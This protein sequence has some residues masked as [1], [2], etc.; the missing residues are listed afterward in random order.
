MTG[1]PDSGVTAPAGFR[2]SGVRCGIRANQ[3]DLALLVSEREAA[4]AAVFTRNRVQAAPVVLSRQALE[5]SGG[6][7]RAVVVNSGNANACTGPAGDLAARR[8]AEELA[9][10]LDLPVDRVLV[11]STGVIGQ[12]LPVD[13]LIDGLP[14]AIAELSPAGGGDAAEAI[15]TTD[16]CR[17]ESVRRVDEPAGGYTLGGMVKGSGMIHP[18]LATT[19]AFV[20]TDAAL[21]PATLAAILRRAADRS[22]N[23]L[24][25]DGDTSTNDMIGLLANG[26]SGVAPDGE[27]FERALT[28]LLVEMARAVARDGEGATR[29]LTVRVVA[30]AT[31]A[32][33]LAVARTVA[34]SLLV[35]TAVHGADANWGRIA[36]AAGRAGVDLEPEALAVRI[37]GLEVLSPGYRSEFSEEEASRRLA[38]DEVVLEVD[39]A[40]GEA[41]AS[42]WTCDLSERYIQIN[43]DYRT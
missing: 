5:S 38:A 9:R 7:A 16:P 35:K 37:N 15:L 19:L 24:T 36:A 2:A 12:P 30:A 25:V 21:P 8:T 39:L 11:A 29:L 42:T 6:R 40:A 3:P 1:R 22:F 13:R 27:A 34:G 10:R 41:E 18:D 31:E 23:R 17:K 32:D 33:A 26:A 14:R 20:T 28:E 43:A 4:A